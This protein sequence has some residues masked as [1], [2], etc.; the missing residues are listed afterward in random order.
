ME[1]VRCPFVDMLGVCH[2]RTALLYLRPWCG[3]KQHAVRSCTQADDVDRNGIGQ[4]VR[5]YSAGKDSFGRERVRL[6]MRPLVDL[7]PALAN[8]IQT[9]KS[10]I[11]RLVGPRAHQG[12]Y[13]TDIEA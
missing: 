4:L 6:V 12:T 7:G 2:L 3:R 13:E 8:N 5:L 9:S 11:G 1:D 10:R